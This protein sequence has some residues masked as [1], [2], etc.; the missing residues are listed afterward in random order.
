M[1]KLKLKVGL[2]YFSLFSVTL[3]SGTEAPPAVQLEHKTLNN[4]STTTTAAL[5][6]A[7]LTSTTA[8]APPALCF[9]IKTTTINLFQPIQAVHL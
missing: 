1:N 3:C 9:I 6:C 8:S 4:H 7:M 5:T 2:L